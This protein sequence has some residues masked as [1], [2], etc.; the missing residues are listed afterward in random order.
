MKQIDM[1]ERGEEKASDEE[2]N[3]TE[4]G[5]AV[6]S[7]QQQQ[8][9]SSNPATIFFMILN[10]EKPQFSLQGGIEGDQLGLMTM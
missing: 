9:D 3:I 2:H 10:L 7:S 8:T 6:G 1:G 5:I 4:E